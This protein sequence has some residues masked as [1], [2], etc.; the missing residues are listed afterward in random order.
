MQSFSSVF[1][2]T[3]VCFPASIQVKKISLFHALTLRLHSSVQKATAHI[4]P[5]N[6]GFFKNYQKRK[7]KKKRKVKEKKDYEKQQGIQQ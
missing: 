7:E 5:Y 6:L 3:L 2:W 4:H 1:I